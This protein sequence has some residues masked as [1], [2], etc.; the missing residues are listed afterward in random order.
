MKPIP[1]E[2]LPVTVYGGEGYI[3]LPTANLG[4]RTTSRWK[5]DWRERFK[6]LVSGEIWLSVLTFGGPLQPVKL[7]V[8]CP[9]VMEITA[10]EQQSEVL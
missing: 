4:G 8:D 1:I 10:A 3:P 6:V 9:I 2:G 5:L 7:E